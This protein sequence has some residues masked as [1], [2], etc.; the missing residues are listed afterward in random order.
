M[1]SWLLSLLESVTF[2]GVFIIAIYVM[3]PLTLKNWQTW[4]KTGKSS[5]LS[6]SIA[7]GTAAFFLLIA[8]LLIFTRSFWR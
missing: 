3:V 2:I 6:N 5:S 7:A 1:E 8:D 4:K